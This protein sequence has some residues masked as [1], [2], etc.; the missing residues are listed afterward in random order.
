MRVS[1]GGD[2]G[3]SG[4]EIRAARDIVRQKVWS[5][6]GKMDDKHDPPRKVHDAALSGSFDTLVMTELGPG[7]AYTVIDNSDVFKHFERNIPIPIED[8][9]LRTDLAQ[10]LEYYLFD[11]SVI[12]YP[13]AGYV[14][15]P[16]WDLKDANERARK[17]V[18]Q[19]LSSHVP[20]LPQMQ[21]HFFRKILDVT[22]LV[23]R[24]PLVSDSEHIHVGADMSTPVKTID[25]V[26]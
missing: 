23:C 5:I 10:T 25:Y 20:R 14:V 13:G 19:H 8:E 21:D 12:M 6:D 7:W 9:S 16:A 15:F 24:D 11:F 18:T 4:S 3:E 26:F 1:G 2:G 22:D 17:F